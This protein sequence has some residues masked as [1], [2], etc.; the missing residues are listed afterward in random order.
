MLSLLRK[1]IQEFGAWLKNNHFK[2][3]GIPDEIIEKIG[4][5]DPT[6]LFYERFEHPPVE[7][8][9]SF[10][11]FDDSNLVLLDYG[12]FFHQYEWKK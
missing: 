8:E 6:N 3:A 1:S 12:G 5:K 4:L 11:T 9:Y 7:H 2:D 10:V